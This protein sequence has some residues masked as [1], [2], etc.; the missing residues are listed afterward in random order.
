MKMNRLYEGQ[1][2]D[3]DLMAQ[4]C[5]DKSWSGLA[6]WLGITYSTMTRLRNGEIAVSPDLWM[7][8]RYMQQ[9]GEIPKKA[10]D[11]D[12]ERLSRRFIATDLDRVK[13]QYESLTWTDIAVY[14]GRMPSALSAI[15]SG[16]SNTNTYFRILVLYISHFGFHPN[17]HMPE[18]PSRKKNG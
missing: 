13:A 1:I 11:G 18:K 9:F 12:F 14:L 3:F 5:P 8:Y 4:L 17:D 7:L 15:R 10:Y 6:R 16:R 2:L